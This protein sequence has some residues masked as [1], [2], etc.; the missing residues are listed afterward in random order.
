MIHR[1]PQKGR[2]HRTA[3]MAISF[4]VV[5]FLFIPMVSAVWWNPFTWFN[6][7][8]LVKTG[9]WYLDHIDGIQLEYFNYTIENSENG[10]AKIC[11][12]PKEAM[13]INNEIITQSKATLRKNNIQTGAIQPSDMETESESGTIKKMC[14][15][16]DKE[17]ED[18]IRFGEN[19]ALFEYTNESITAYDDGEYLG[20]ISLITEDFYYKNGKPNIQLGVGKNQLTHLFY[21]E[22]YETDAITNLKT[23]NMGSGEEIERNV[24]LKWL[25]YYEEE[26]PTYYEECDFNEVCNKTQNGT[27][28]VYRENWSSMDTAI[29]GE[30]YVVGVFADTKNRDYVDIDFDFY[31]VSVLESP[32]NWATWNA[33]YE[34][35][36]LAAFKFQETTGAVIDSWGTYDGTNNGAQRGVPGYD[37]YGFNFTRTEGDTVQTGTLSSFSDISVVLKFRTNDVDDGVSPTLRGL[38]T[39]SD[40]PRVFYQTNDDTW[41]L[42]D[43]TGSAAIAGESATQLEE[44]DWHTMIYMY[45]SA[46]PTSYL[47]I[48]N[49]T[50]LIGNTTLSNSG[51]FTQ[52]YINLGRGRLASPGYW[53][54]EIDEVLV[55]NR[56]LTSAERIAFSE[57]TTFPLNPDYTPTIILNSPANDTTYTNTTTAQFNSTIYDDINL[58]NVSLEIDG[59]IDQTNSSGINNSDYI[60]T[61]SLAT[62]IHNWSIIACDNSSQCTQSETRILNISI[63]SPTIILYT[64]ADSLE[65]SN[66]TQN[67]TSFVYDGDGGITNVSLYL[68]SALNETNTS[69]INGTNYTFTKTLSDG[70]HS[71][72]IKAYDNLGYVTDSA[73]RTLTIDTTQPSIN[74]TSPIETYDY[75]E[76]NYTLSLNWSV[77]DAHLDSCWYVYNGTT[78]NLNCSDNQTNFNYEVGLNSLIFYSNDTFGNERNETTSWGYVVLERA[79]DYPSPT[80]EGSSDNLILNMTLNS[81]LRIS[82]IYLNYNGTNETAT[83][84]VSGDN[85]TINTAHIALPS[86]DSTNYTFY[87]IIIYEDD[88]TY[89]STQQI[90][91]VNDLGIDDCSNYT[92]LLFNFTLVDEAT[93]DFLNGTEQNTSIKLDFALSDSEGENEVISIS[94]NFNK[95]NPAA[96]CIKESLGESTYLL[97]GVVEYSSANR[98]VEFYNIEDYVMT[99]STANQNITLY[100]LLESEGQEFKITYKGQDFIPVTNLLLQIQRNY[101]DEGQFKTIEIPMSGSN[102]YTIAH[103]VPN[104]VIYNLIFIKDGAILDTFAE[105]IADCQNPDITECEIN[106]NSL[107]TG[108][109]LFDLI[110]D[111]EFAS[112]LEFDRDTRV[113]SS[114][115]SI[116]SGVSDL[117]QLNVTLMDNFGNNTACT[118]S[119]FAAGG[120]L[121]CTVPDSFGNST[122]YAKVTYDGEPKH[123]G[124]ISMSESP[125]EQ[126][127]GI[128]IISSLILL[129]LIFGIGL[130]DNPF[131]T[132]AFFIVGALV[133][134]GLNL[135]YSTSWLGA[136]ATILWF[137]IA[138]IAVIMKGGNKR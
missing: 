79:W 125:K 100:N 39:F 26:I 53:N 1:Q 62:G 50:D 20:E 43:G 135:F 45:D 105:V 6:D 114:T 132:A 30:G 128:L 109:D 110:E 67:F 131:I 99:E 42:Q 44:N 29:E 60:F 78:N 49:S 133:L 137:I 11:L 55:Y 136:G 63:I 65:T 77:S 80:L 56:T 123:E 126:Y 103:L 122:I 112:S 82:T 48:Y 23:I 40:Y 19:S 118:D 72:Y 58:I 124:Y 87:Y 59:N 73:T 68:D 98:F 83:Y 108:L 116:L 134:V 57:N 32:I 92:N 94:Q 96:V 22:N 24:N 47:Y 18:Y 97:N 130:N 4:L 88:S 113:V 10:K 115:F 86:E 38:M 66:P 13:K 104:D 35:G 46:G 34:N 107:I 129:M 3:L 51:T 8:D 16:V 54:G 31:G 27:K 76:E 71:W 84:S 14:I 36:L 2:T 127:A 89:F 93:Q 75:L 117:V 12:I 21:I 17:E 41:G 138:I 111:D 70:S 85:Y 102:G 15:D 119:L 64:P 121:T 7:N 52:N 106:L 9:G 91:V 81:T 28:I 90:Q 101:I 33:S 74:I 61:K 95:T 37:G 120:T 69:G 5:A 25:S